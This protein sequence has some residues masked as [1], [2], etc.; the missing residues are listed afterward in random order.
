MKKNYKK[1]L[2]FITLLLA[3]LLIATVSAT[4]YYSLSMET[5]ITVGTTW[6]KFIS[7]DDTPSGSTITDTTC[8]LSLSTLANSTLVYEKAIGLSNTYTD[9]R[10]IRLRHVSVSPNGTA[11][12]SNFTYVKF[13]LLDASLTA[14]ASLNY[15]TSGDNWS[16]TSTTNWIAIPGSTTWYIKVET[17]SPAGATAGTQCTITI[18]VDVQQ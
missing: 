9:N 14:Q 13:Y 11:P 8:S 10:Y 7:A 18:A 1:S 17:F 15:T 3:S 16:V 2:K 5:K 4:V 12:V 6:V